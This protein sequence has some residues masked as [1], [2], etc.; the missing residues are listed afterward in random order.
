MINTTCNMIFIVTQSILFHSSPH[1]C[2]YMKIIVHNPSNMR[3]VHACEWDAWFAA[4]LIHSIHSQV[5][6]LTGRS[7][8]DTVVAD[9]GVATGSASF[10][11]LAHT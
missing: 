9:I 3:V 2:S 6:S 8:V 11:S 5:A 1:S 4:W 7:G 10:T